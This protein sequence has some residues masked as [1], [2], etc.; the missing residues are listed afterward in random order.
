MYTGIYTG[1]HIIKW[2]LGVYFSTFYKSENIFFYLS[3]V[4]KI[5]FL[6]ETYIQFF[7]SSWKVIKKYMT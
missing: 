6:L 7:N 5:F 4:K 3:N 1:G 2:H